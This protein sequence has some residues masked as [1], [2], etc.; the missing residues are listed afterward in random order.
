MNLNKDLFF[1]KNFFIKRKP[2]I[3]YDGLQ[4]EQKLYYPN[5]NKIKIRYS[6]RPK[7]I[8]LNKINAINNGKIINNIITPSEKSYFTETNQSQINGGDIFGYN[9][10]IINKNSFNTINF[11]SKKNSN[12]KNESISNFNYAD[13]PNYLTAYESSTNFRLNNINN[14]PNQYQMTNPNNNSN[15]FN[16]SDIK[17]MNMKLNFKILQ[18]KLSHLN[19][20]ATTNFKDSYKTP[21]KMNMNTSS[22]Y[23]TELSNKNYPIKVFRSEMI[24]NNT[25]KLK[26]VLKAKKNKDD[27]YQIMGS[28]NDLINNNMKIM[29]NK[30]LRQKIL[31]KNKNKK[32]TDIFK[33]KIINNRYKNYIKD[34][35]YTNENSLTKNYKNDE[36]DLS[37]IA[38]N[39]IELNNSSENL[40]NNYFIKDKS[41]EI[42]NIKMKIN[43]LKKNAD[44]KIKNKNKKNQFK[45]ISNDF[46]ESSS[47]KEYNQTQNNNNQNIQLIVEH[48][49]SYDSTK[50]KKSVTEQNS[51]KSKS[52][53]RIK[54]NKNINIVQTNNFILNNLTEHSKNRRE[55]R[56]KI[57]NNY[58]DINL[59]NENSVKNKIKEEDSNDEN[60]N[61][62]EDD[63]D[64]IINSLLAT[65]SQNFKHQKAITNNNT[66][67]DFHKSLMK[68]N[69]IN[70]KNKK[71]VTFDNNLIYINY[72]QDYKVTN[73]QITDNNN[74]IIK[75]K[76]ID[77]SKYLK[78]LESNNDQL[79]PIITN[80]NKTNYINIINKIKLKNTNSKINKIKA[81]Q[82]IKRNIEYIKEV[83]KRNNSKERNQSKDKNKK[84]YE[85]S[86]N[87]INIKVNK[88]NNNNN[89]IIVN[90][91]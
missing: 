45:F 54:N 85:L 28:Q 64:K 59:K 69:Q 19:D 31:N 3:R 36:N 67:T 63:G 40:D 20:I 39:I 79:K 9:N 10:Y 23:S 14:N 51:D 29:N 15:S 43:D 75:F 68:D 17:Y 72:H 81:N 76:P 62:E 57:E 78:K 37:Q 46:G 13:T 25:N 86:N 60:E 84:K 38:D 8:F 24:N 87:S 33:D 53:R 2:K 89:K 77:I 73:L 70:K 83:E 21:Y 91:K 49:F 90:K 44:I 50:I 11:T 71:P 80:S 1:T 7:D 42:Q 22:G 4:T 41:F 32:E 55:E 56:P 16:N 12:Q 47:N 66:I 35:Y 88:F 61:N 52:N 27:I 6:K 48:I 74:K 18:K 5:T 65:A 82:I 58:T 34:R 30:I 26:K